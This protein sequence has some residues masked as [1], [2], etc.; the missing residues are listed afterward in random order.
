MKPSKYAGKEL[1]YIQRMME[2]FDFDD[3]VRTFEQKFSEKIGGRH[4]IAVNS[5]TSALHAA[6]VA[7]EVKGGEVL[8][9]A[10][11]PAMV[12]FAVIHAGATPVFCDV[13]SN[14]YNLNPENAAIKLTEN[15]KAI[16]GVS[17]HGLPM[18]WNGLII[19]ACGMYIGLMIAPKP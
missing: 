11:C 10:L 2:G 3:W 18:S 1:H 9:P 16:L 19:K 14:T 17:L 4:C 15:T 7:C 5:G 13:D 12:A 8:L 6:L